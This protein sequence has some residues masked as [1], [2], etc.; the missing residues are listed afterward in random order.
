[1]LEILGYSTSEENKQTTEQWASAFA[2]EVQPETDVKNILPSAYVSL[3]PTD[4]AFPDRIFGSHVQDVLALK[5]K[6][7]PENVFTLTVPLLKK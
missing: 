5:K 6:H 2:D 1:M 3:D 7:D 4:K